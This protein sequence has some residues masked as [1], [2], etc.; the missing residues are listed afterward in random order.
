[1]KLRQS[2]QTT[3][4]RRRAAPALDQALERLHLDQCRRLA[5]ALGP[6]G[7]AARPAATPR[8]SR[9]KYA[10]WAAAADPGACGATAL[11]TGTEAVSPELRARLWSIFY[12]SLGGSPSNL[13]S[14]LFEVEGPVLSLLYDYHVGRLHLA[15]D[16][17]TSSTE[18]WTRKLKSIFMDGDYLGIFGCVQWVLR[19]KAKPIGLEIEI[20]TA[21]RLS[22]AAYGLFDKATIIPTGTDAERETLVRVFSDL[23]ASEFHGARAHLRNAGSELT[24]GNY[25]T[26]VRESI[27]A[28]ESVARVLEPT[29]NALGP[30]LSKLE[31]SAYIHG[32]L[33]AGFRNL[34]GFTS[35]EEG[36]RHPLLDKSSAQVDELDAL[37][38]LGSCAAFVSY[39]INKAREAG[40]LNDR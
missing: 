24:A 21:L 37:Y 25:S 4:S 40:L 6:A 31:K 5:L 20:E 29:A 12:K 3:R 36:I 35:D 10:D 23:A 22:G 11:T 17:F 9:L 33:G 16:E 28:V 39:L 38:M 32:A 13:L 18:Y 34:Y 19:H 15:A 14:D 27:Q 30:A 7:P 1:V 26:S 2:S 8:R